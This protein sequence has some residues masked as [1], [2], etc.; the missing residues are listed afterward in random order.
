MFQKNGSVIFER[1]VGVRRAWSKYIEK[2]C[3]TLIKNNLVEFPEYQI[4]VTQTVEMRARN[5]II[6]LGY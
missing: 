2:K 3:T 1:F 5:F 6:C 4:P